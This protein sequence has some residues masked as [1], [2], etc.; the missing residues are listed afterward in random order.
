MGREEKIWLMA[1]RGRSAHMGIRRRQVQASALVN[2]TASLGVNPANRPG[3]VIVD[4]LHKT[5]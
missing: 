5:T 1:G 2:A 3:K 4:P